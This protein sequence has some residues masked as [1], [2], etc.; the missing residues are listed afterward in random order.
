MRPLILSSAVA[1]ALAAWAQAAPLVPK[2]AS[3]ELRSTPLVELVAQDC[4]WGWHRAQW[5]DRWVYW[6]WGRWVPN[7]R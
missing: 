2:L 5:R 4:G 1:L 3:L 6:H 7:W